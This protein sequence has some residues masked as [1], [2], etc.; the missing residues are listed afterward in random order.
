M[1]PSLPATIREN[2]SIKSYVLA[3]HIRAGDDIG[4][5]NGGFGPVADLW[6]RQEPERR[7]N[8]RS[9]HH[10]WTVGKRTAAWTRHRQGRSR[11]IREAL[12]PWTR[13][14]RRSNEYSVPGCVRRETQE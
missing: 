14:K 8:S 12:S 3:K 7:G 4:D 9:R 10:C 6:C 2:T 5:C 11:D 13:W 1:A